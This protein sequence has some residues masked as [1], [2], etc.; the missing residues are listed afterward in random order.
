[1]VITELRCKGGHALLDEGGW[2]RMVQLTAKSTA[3]T[4]C[5]RFI[6]NHRANGWHSLCGIVSYV[7]SS[8]TGGFTELDKRTVS[9]RYVSLSVDFFYFEQEGS[10]FQR[11]S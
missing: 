8:T 3:F 5:L 4:P 6:S 11:V 1:M 7:F 2:V 9:L 10:L